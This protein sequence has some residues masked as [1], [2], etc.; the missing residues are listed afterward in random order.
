VN[1]SSRALCALVVAAL[2]L[3]ALAPARLHAAPPQSSPPAHRALFQRLA[4]SSPG[5]LE[6]AFE[7]ATYVELTRRHARG[8]S[9]VLD[10]W[11]LPGGRATSATLLPVSAFEPGARAQIV[12][13][14]GSLTWQAPSV[15]CFRGALQEGGEVFFGITAESLEGYFRQDGALYFLSSAGCAPGH[16]TLAHAD[17]LARSE[18]KGDFCGVRGGPQLAPG[19]GPGTGT[20][21]RSVAGP[22]LRTASVFLEADPAYR[23]LFASNQACIDYTALLLSAASEIYRRDLGL[24]LLLPNGYLRLWSTT[25]P[26][27]TVT[28]FNDIDHVRDYWTS[29]ANPDRSL[30]RSAVHVLSSPVF[31]GVAYTIGGLCINSQGYEISSLYGHFPS[32]RQHTSDD[33]WDLYVLTHEF[34]HTFGCMHSF[35]FQPPIQCADG[36]GPDQGTIMSYCH[37][38][39]GVGGVGMRFH[40]REQREILDHVDT[41]GCLVGQ[42][43][44]LGDY[45]ADGAADLDDLAT[46]NAILGQGFRSLGAEAVFDLDGDGRFD[47]ADRDR[48]ALQVGAPPASAVSRNGSGSNDECLL[49]FSNPVLGRAWALD[50]VASPA[51]RPTAI[52]FFDRPHPGLHTPF[53]ELLVLPPGQGGRELFTH[54]AASTGFLATHD[55]ALPFDVNLIGLT[56]TVQGVVIGAP[57]TQLCNAFDVVLSPYE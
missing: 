10:P 47:A 20:P 35:D 9:F 2:V 12:G 45:D 19:T 28:T 1:D 38:T 55:L 4:E 54:T 49:T 5:V 41:V 13:A 11:P 6:L 46:A 3:A 27:G 51:G 43:L 24:R 57:H 31:G 21:E 15:R 7:P 29:L 25:P 30:P 17:A 48:L 52:F 56:A 53:G 33:N 37:L 34:G 18:P 22:R 23:Q 32:P 39:F 26:W 16:A 44:A 14:D 42:T 36:S 50:V 8:T 40:V